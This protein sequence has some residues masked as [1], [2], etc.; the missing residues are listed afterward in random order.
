[1][2]TCQNQNILWLVIF[3]NIDVLV[4]SIGST[5]IPVLFIHSLRGWK[6]INVLNHLIPEE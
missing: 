2:I 4:N 3:D 6:E 5:L 1:M